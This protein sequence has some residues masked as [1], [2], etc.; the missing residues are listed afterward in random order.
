MTFDQLAAGP[1]IEEAEAYLRAPSVHVSCQK[2]TRD[3]LIPYVDERVPRTF[4]STIERRGSDRMGKRTI[5]LKDVRRFGIEFILAE[6][7]WVPYTKHWRRI[8]PFFQGEKM[9]VEARVAEYRRAN[10]T[11]D[12]NLRIEKVAKL[13]L[14]R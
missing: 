11:Y 4:I 7:M 9:V 8:E 14:T 10:G 2:G 3:N 1:S 5:L 13:W 6:H 12:F